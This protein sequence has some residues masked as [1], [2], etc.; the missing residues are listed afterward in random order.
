[1][2]IRYVA[3]YGASRKAVPESVRVAIRMAVSGLY[4]MREP[5]IVGTIPT[6]AEA[7]GG[8]SDAIQMLMANE[9]VWAI[10]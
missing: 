4:E 1:M 3:G 6:V 9:R 5:S 2:T 7:L 8:K 10:R